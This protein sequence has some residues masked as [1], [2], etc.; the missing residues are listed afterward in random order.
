LIY[1]FGYKAKGKIKENKKDNYSLMNQVR[2][3]QREV[4]PKEPAYNKS[5]SEPT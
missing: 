1:I 3:N 4:L 5:E 2:K